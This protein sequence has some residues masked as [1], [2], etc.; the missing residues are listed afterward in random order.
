[1][2]LKRFAISNTLVGLYVVFLWH[3][4]IRFPDSQLFVAA[5]FAAAFQL[6]GRYR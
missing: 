6:D 5:V 2:K 1:M 3:N 4:G